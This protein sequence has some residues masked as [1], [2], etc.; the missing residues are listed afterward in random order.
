M[1]D[2][3]DWKGSQT[4]HDIVTP[5]KL[6]RFRATIDAPVQSGAADDVPQAFHWCLCLPDTPTGNLGVDGH[7]PK[8]GFLPPI[9]LP[10][11]MWAASDVTFLSLIT[12]AAAIERTSTVASVT[13]KSGKSGTLFF[14]E[15]DHLTLSDGTPAVRERQSIVYRAATTE[16]APLPPVADVDLAGWDW[17]RSLTPDTAMLFRYSAMTFNTHR[18]HYD[19]PY[20]REEELYPGL[21][22]HGPLMATLLVDHCARRFGP[23][24]LARFSYRALSPA[25][26]GQPLHLVGR[27][28]GDALE[29]KAL[30]GD[31]RTVVS[32]GATLRA[33]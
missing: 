26:A 22:V 23:D 8:G 15:V 28:D 4:L 31:G 32:A 1:S 17:T 5:D 2:F 12:P 19:L 29:L 33:G 9:P 27:R 6:A 16:R 20:A 30:G 14:V 11:R 21:V 13:E 18:I 24:A 3:S 10:R 25:F 7:P